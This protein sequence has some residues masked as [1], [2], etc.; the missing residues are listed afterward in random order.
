MER[1]RPVRWT[2]M[3]LQ[4]PSAENSWT[5]LS[6]QALPVGSVTDWAVRPDCGALVLF[7]GTTRDHAEG[8]EGVTQLEYEAYEEP[9]LRCFVEIEQAARQ[10]WPAVG[11]IALLHRVGV[12]ELG[13]SA[14]LVAVSAPHRQD[15]F[16]AAR[17]C[18]DT[19]KETAPIWKRETWKS[20]SAWGTDAREIRRIEE[21]SR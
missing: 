21:V 16:E 12:V 18:I 9:T 6:S 11:R 4:P 2:G 14:V 19:L 10:R 3:N 1:A 7:N 15:A 5:A 8:R 20:G 13:E 17:F